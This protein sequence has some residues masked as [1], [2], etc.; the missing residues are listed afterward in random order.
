MEEKET[1]LGEVLI[2]DQEQWHDYYFR[3][4][5]D[6][7]YMAMNDPLLYRVHRAG[8]DPQLP[9]VFRVERKG[10]S[11]YGILTFV[12][13]GRGS[14]TYEGQVYPLNKGDLFVLPPGIPHVYDSDR[15]SPMGQIW[16]EIDGGD[17]ERIMKSVVSVLG[18]VL[19]DR[20]SNRIGSRMSQLIQKLSI[21]DYLDIPVIVYQILSDLIFEKN[22]FTQEDKS[23]VTVSVHMT[24]SY[25]DAH[26]SE[27]ITNEK[28]AE[29]SGLSKSYFMKMFKSTYR[30]TPQEYMMYQKVE[31][32][33]HY[34]IH[35]N[36]AVGELGEK[37]G[38]STTSHF[39]KR[40][41]KHFGV[42]PAVYRRQ[43]KQI[44]V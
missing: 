25:M 39:I 2:S 8:L 37:L 19:H 10:G 5:L 44:S 17:C 6:D 33:R 15:T 40:Y 11:H 22:S 7:T 32:A 34:L 36:I 9:E 28:L 35:S 13:R 18:P 23:E 41:K 4:D 14:V 1:L 38:F 26:I 43:A 21:S 30:K 31:S 20:I 12:F 27:V 29:I 42:T 24:K 16:I 3:C